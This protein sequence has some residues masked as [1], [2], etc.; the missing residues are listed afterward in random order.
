MTNL[1]TRNVDPTLLF[2]HAS[3]PQKSEYPDALLFG[4][5][6]LCRD[7]PFITNLRKQVILCIIYYGRWRAIDKTIKLFGSKL[8]HTTRLRQ[9]KCPDLAAFEKYSKM[10]SH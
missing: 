10:Y 6:F 3:I 1:D 4:D 8:G 7:V 5:I 9:R 2:S